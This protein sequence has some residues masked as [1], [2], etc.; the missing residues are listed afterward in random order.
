[1]ILDS[2]FRNSITSYLE[3]EK[4]GNVE[5][6]DKVTVLLNEVG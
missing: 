5:E 6:L 2:Q 1:M 3:H 4:K